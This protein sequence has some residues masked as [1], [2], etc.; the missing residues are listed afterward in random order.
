MIDSYTS[1]GA[2]QLF[3]EEYTGKLA[4]GMSA[5][6]LILDRDLNKT[7][8]MDIEFTKVKSVMFKGAFLTK[9]E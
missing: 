4:E 6:L 2:Y 5:D 8:I 1:A 3:M 7:D 9:S